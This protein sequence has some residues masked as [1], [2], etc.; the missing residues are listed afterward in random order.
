MPE[1]ILEPA[2]QLDVIEDA[3]VVVVGGGPGGLPAAVAAARQ[4]AKTVLVERYGVLG[5]LATS[6][7]M[8]PLYGYAPVGGALY[9]TDRNRLERGGTVLGGIPVELVR[10]LQKIGG[11]FG[12]DKLQWE[13]VR[14][15]PELFKFVCDDI[16]Q[17]A[18]VKILL[19]AWAVGAV[20]ENNRIS[21]LIVESKSGRQA[22]T[23]KVFVD[24]TGD[25]DLAWF[26]G[27]SYTKGRPGDGRTLALGS[28]FRMGGI[29]PR[30][31][32]EV[33]LC[34]KITAEGIAKG[35]LESMN[36]TDFMDCGSSLRDGDSCPDIT[37]RPGDG[38]NMRDLTRCELDIRK[39][40]LNIVEFMKK[41]VP[42][43]ESSY[44]IDSPF[45]V[46]VRETRQIHG[47]YTLTT[48]DVVNVRKSPDTTVA[49]G[50]WFLDMHCCMGYHHPGPF[51]EAICSVDCNTGKPCIM[52]TEEYRDDLL[53]SSH[54]PEGE[55]YD[56]PYG[57]L[58]AKDV[59]NLL[60]SGRCVSAS[61]EA[62]SSLR[63]IATCFAI[64][65]AAGVAGALSVQ[66]E[67]DPRDLDVSEIQ[68]QLRDNGVPL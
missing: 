45:Q 29:R 34:E 25:G 28:R 42:G 61:H 7:L 17:E 9:H 33:K 58:V 64:G 48:D 52:K 68:Q 4:G 3:D 18:G 30:T 55:Y 12:D 24:G 14:F 39:D 47:T 66:R 38:T 26:S 23:G 60:V 10:R 21:A 44:L 54:L 22:I 43:F 16:V 67:K 41:N 37:R 32:E 50:C 8:G 6:G 20:V 36:E 65:E 27:C 11:A 49:R 1:K 40:T 5:G 19:H 2:R 62:M 63:V 51:D 56:I 13:S 15:D 46:G 59:S 53:K 35:E 31:A 57:C